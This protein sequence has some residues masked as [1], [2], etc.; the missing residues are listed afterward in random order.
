MDDSH[1]QYAEPLAQCQDGDIS[2]FCDDCNDLVEENA[3][4]STKSDLSGTK[5]RYFSFEHAVMGKSKPKRRKQ[6][7]SVHRKLDTCLTIDPNTELP[8]K[9]QNKAPLKAGEVT[10]LV[11]RG[12]RRRRPATL[13]QEHGMDSGSL[14]KEEPSVRT[15]KES[16]QESNWLSV[17]RGDVEL[18]PDD[19]STFDESIA[20][21]EQNAIVALNDLKNERSFDNVPSS[22]LSSLGSSPSP[23]EW[24]SQEIL[25]EGRSD[26]TFEPQ[27]HDAQPRDSQI[28]PE[29]R[30]SPQTISRI[31][32]L[33]KA[34]TEGSSDLQ[35]SPVRPKLTRK[36]SQFFPKQ[37][38]AKVSCVPFPPLDSVSFGLVQERL[39]HDPFRLLIAVM[40]LNKT[41]GKVAMP[42]CYKLFEKY[43]TAEDFASADQ[44]E[45][46]EMI[47]PLG[48]Q[49]ARATRM[50]K[51][52]KGWLESTPQKG[53]RYAKLDYPKKGDGKDIPKSEGPISDDDPRVAWEIAHLPGT[54]AYALDSWRVFCRDELR[55]L[56][57]G[58]P[59]VLTPKAIDEELEK[60]WTRVLPLDKELR[61][62]LRWR[63]LRLG[64]RW[65]PITGE[66][67]PLDASEMEELQNGGVFYDGVDGDIRSSR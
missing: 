15:G 10:P 49:N 55:G 31:K 38:A 54:G 2:V 11:A 57:T 18:N 41:R 52:A 14:A 8:R 56:P 66:R 39:C 48:L 47:Q 20:I 22:P 33:R 5:S 16:D 21:E 26:C 53:R 60:E 42:L 59:Q 6:G 58:V 30:S 24:L 12:S 65:D 46:C 51:L 35:V 32:L 67:A 9:A 61:A 19:S 62:Y 17:R 7:S 64:W 27:L 34:N 45:I 13:V 43:P 28:S 3:K 44:T 23:P 4:P 25:F 63:W 50:I 1:I 37:P 40:L 29:S 36:T